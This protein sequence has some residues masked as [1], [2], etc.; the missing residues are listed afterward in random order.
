MR[1]RRG[2]YFPHQILA[3]DAE[4]HRAPAA[5]VAGDLG[6]RQER[7]LDAVEPRHGAAIVARAARLDEVEAGAG[8]KRLG[9]LLQPAFRRHREDE[10]AHGPDVPPGLP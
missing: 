5:S 4:M 6:R 3:G 1:V 8:E 10:G 7:H 9:V 2:N